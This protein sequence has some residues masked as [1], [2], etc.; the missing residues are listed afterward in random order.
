MGAWMTFL[1]ERLPLPSYLVLVMGLAISGSALGNAS[2]A[3]RPSAAIWGATAIA[4]AGA[5][6]FFAVLRIM[7]EYKDYEKD[8]VA[9]PHRPL[10]RDSLHQNRWRA[11]STDW[12]SQC[13]SLVLSSGSAT[14]RQASVI[15][16]SLAICG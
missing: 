16:W 2:A 8:R 13:S 7:D 9:H 11:P 6:M 4:A 12:R 1:K 3:V 14:A 10:P 5:F 15:Y